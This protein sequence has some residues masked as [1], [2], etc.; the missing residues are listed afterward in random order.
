MAVALTTLP[1]SDIWQGQPLVAYRYKPKS[2]P[3]RNR[4]RHRSEGNIDSSASNHSL[5]QAKLPCDSAENAQSDLIIAQS[6]P[7]ARTTS[8][9]HRDSPSA[10]QE[11]EVSQSTRILG[12]KEDDKPSDRRAQHFANGSY[13]GQD[14]SEHAVSSALTD[15]QT[16]TTTIVATKGIPIL[17]GEGTVTKKKSKGKKKR[18]KDWDPKP[19]TDSVLDSSLN[20][21]TEPGKDLAK[22]FP[23][24]TSSSPTFCNGLPSTAAAAESHIRTKTFAKAARQAASRIED[25]SVQLAPPKTSCRQH[26]ELD[27]LNQGLSTK[28]GASCPSRKVVGKSRKA[29]GP[30][31]HATCAGGAPDTEC[32]EP[33]SASL[34]P[35][36]NCSMNNSTSSTPIPGIEFQSSQPESQSIKRTS[37][38]SI[39]STAGSPP[40]ALPSTGATSHQQT[41]RRDS[42]ATYE[43]PLIGSWQGSGSVSGVDPE[44]SC[45]RLQINALENEPTHTTVFEDARGTS[46]DREQETILEKYGQ[47]IASTAAAPATPTLPLSSYR[48]P[49]RSP[50]RLAISERRNSVSKSSTPG[51]I[52]THKK[53]ARQ[54]GLTPTKQT[55][56]SSSKARSVVESSPSQYRYPGLGTPS[57]L[58]VTKYHDANA[59]VRKTLH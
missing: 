50:Q 37:S 16:N 48:T 9:F 33:A 34:T 1:V 52:T 35:T 8:S 11:L 26:G 2:L 22:E 38:S 55:F 54:K 20:E 18:A 44:H 21:L 13:K 15:H 24:L 45:S 32:Q 4:D 6:L 30:E 36:S 39:D 51:P 7:S 42:K 46:S 56:P 10:K 43:Q 59:V 25:E 5:A 53:S 47:D 19:K 40:A 14:Q 41:S 3:Y 49:S 27:G 31:G 23:P 29:A 28:N 58:L 12:E 17:A 57:T